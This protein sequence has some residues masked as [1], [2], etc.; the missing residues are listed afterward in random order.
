MQLFFLRCNASGT[1]VYSVATNTSSVSTISRHILP[2]V[3]A[4]KFTSNENN[5]KRALTIRQSKE[6]K[7][8]FSKEESLCEPHGQ[9][10]YYNEYFAKPVLEPVNKAS[11]SIDN[12]NIITLRDDWLPISHGLFYNTVRFRFYYT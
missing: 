12:R 7:N 11:R 2:V 3:N 1:W 8:C 9:L 10:K 4:T 6:T 5:A